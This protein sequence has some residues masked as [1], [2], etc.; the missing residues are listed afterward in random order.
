[1]IRG[2]YTAASGMLLNDRQSDTIDQNLENIN[3]P[4]YLQESERVRSFPRL[5]VSR[6]TPSPT[7]SVPSE[8]IPLGILGT[9]VYAEKRL[10][11]AEF[12]KIRE[13]GTLTD[14]ALNCEGYFVVE[15]LQGERYT[16]NGHF[17]RDPAGMLRT[18][19]GNLVLG[20]NGPIGPL[21]D[22]FRITEDGV[23]LAI[24]TTTT[25]D[26]EG[27]EIQI[28]VQREIDRLRIVHTPVENLE[29][30]GLTTLYRA[31]DGEP[32]PVQPEN[33]RVA[34]GFIEDANVDLNAQ[35]V[36]MIQ[37]VRCYSANQKVIQ[38]TDS[39]LAKAVNDIGRT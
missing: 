37:V 35:M 25:E 27:N 38:T 14:V 19:G 28:E 33:I 30:E 3:T 7:N 5:L 20:E 32:V 26:D 24:E 23:I 13:T 21:P 12:G 31:L 11:S 36:K 29:R 34:Q 4:G 16:R 9:G 2:L 22:N 39:L 8:N 10:Y 15:T 18:A 1:L 6:L 17:E